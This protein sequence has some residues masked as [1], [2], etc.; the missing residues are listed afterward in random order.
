M[1]SSGR[2]S[3]VAAGA[4]ALLA[5]GL[6]AWALWPTELP[7][8][9]PPRQADAMTRVGPLLPVR[10]D[11]A[12]A[13]PPFSPTRSAADEA[14]ASAP[15]PT[16]PPLLVGTISDR[17]GGGIALLRASD[18]ETKVVTPGM[19]IEGWTLTAIT[20]GKATLR[21]GDRVETIAFDLSNRSV[22]SADAAELAEQSASKA[23]A[24]AQAVAAKPIAAHSMPSGHDSK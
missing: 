6:P 8:S 10:I 15:P 18:G 5:L 3:M 14:L 24:T 7:D 17:R 2:M 11:R 20:N 1:I 12:I 9:P 13:A 19:V 4:S 21:Q 16:P 22:D 23:P